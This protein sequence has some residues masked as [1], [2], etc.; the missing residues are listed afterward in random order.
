[1]VDG[2][3]PDENDSDF[4]YPDDP[5]DP[6]LLVTNDAVGGEPV[7]PTGH[8]AGPAGSEPLEASPEYDEHEQNSDDGPD[9]LD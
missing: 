3:D 2:T 6:N 5:F 4:S 9:D 7:N 1:M 8:Y